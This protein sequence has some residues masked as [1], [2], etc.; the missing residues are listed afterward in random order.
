MQDDIAIPTW[1]GCRLVEMKHGVFAQ[2]CS[3]HKKAK[4]LCGMEPSPSEMCTK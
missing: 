4:E 3:K 2:V 1:G